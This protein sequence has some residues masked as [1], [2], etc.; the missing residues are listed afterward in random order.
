MYAHN[1]YYEATD[2][3]HAHRFERKIYWVAVRSWYLSKGTVRNCTEQVE[4][5]KL[6]IYIWILENLAIIAILSIGPLYEYIQS[7]RQAPACI[8]LLI[9]RFSYSVIRSKM[10]RHLVHPYVN[11]PIRL[12]MFLSHSPSLYYNANVHLCRVTVLS[13][14]P[15][16]SDL[17]KKSISRTI[18]AQNL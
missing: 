16:L 11:N 7:A 6:I 18:F 5:T 8:S 10:R 2:I 4:I 13:F 9:S 3:F 14:T 17:K 15:S 12:M 1:A